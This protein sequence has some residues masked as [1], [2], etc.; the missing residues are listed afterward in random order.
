[1]GPLF[2]APTNILCQNKQSTG[3]NGFQIYIMLNYTNK[4]MDGFGPVAVL[5]MILTYFR[6]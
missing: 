1:M 5:G 4:Y 2:H 3:Q 6:E